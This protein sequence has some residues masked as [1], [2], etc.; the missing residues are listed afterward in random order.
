MSN[1]FENKYPRELSEIADEIMS[2]KPPITYDDILDFF[3]NLSK[4]EKRISRNKSK[5]KD[6]KAKER[7]LLKSR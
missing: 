5:K 1:F 3:L 7:R 4:L 2:G 6:G